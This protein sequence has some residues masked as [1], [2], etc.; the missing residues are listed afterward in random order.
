MLRLINCWGCRDAGHRE[1]LM[2]VGD[3]GRLGCL[4]RLFG[5]AVGK[6]HGIKIINQFSTVSQTYLG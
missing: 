3:A 5:H 4:P 2:P 1:G 6:L